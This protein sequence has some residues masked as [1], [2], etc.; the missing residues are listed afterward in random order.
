MFLV[1]LILLQVG[2]LSGWASPYLSKL[3]NGTEIQA[4]ESDLTWIAS[5]LNLGR[6]IGS[7]T[8]SIAVSYFGSKRTLLLTLIL[9][10]V[11]WTCT[12]VADRVEWLFLSRLSGGIGL[13]M[14]YSSYPLYLGEISL[15]KTRGAL[16]SLANCG[17]TFGLLTGNVLGAALPMKHSGMIFLTL[18]CVVMLIFVWLPESPHHLVKSN[19]CYL[20]YYFMFSYFK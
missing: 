3:K 20:N 10:I 18:V 6:F 2:V 12:I 16:I 5:L 13:G 7:F 14:I 11:C 15:P 9:F 19:L 8:G 4:N 17:A 1:T